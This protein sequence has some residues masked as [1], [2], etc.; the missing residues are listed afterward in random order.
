MSCTAEGPKGQDKAAAPSP[1]APS[2]PPVIEVQLCP[3][4]KQTSL[5][6]QLALVTALLEAALSDLPAVLPTVEGAPISPGLSGSLT[7]GATQ[8]RVRVAVSSDLQDELDIDVGIDCGSLY[9]P[10]YR[11]HASGDPSVATASI[12]KELARNLGKNVDPETLETWRRPQSKDRYARIVLGRGAAVLYRL[13]PDVP[14][15]QRND[16]RADPFERAVFI[17]PRMWVGHWMAARRRFEGREFALARSAFGRAGFYGRGRVLHL[18]EEA[19]ALSAIG[20]TDVALGSW[21]SVLSRAPRDPRYLLSYAEALLDADRLEDAKRT[22]DELGPQA[23][24]DAKVLELRVRIADEGGRE[25]EDEALLSAWA[26]AAPKDP[27][28]VRRWISLCVRQHELSRA[29]GLVPELERRGAVDEARRFGLSLALS[30]GR[31]DVAEADA[32]SL[33]LSEL[34]AAIRLRA[35]LESGAPP[36]SLLPLAKE[37][38]ERVAVAE[39]FLRG[40]EPGRARTIAEEV[41]EVEPH[42]P[43]ALALRA[44]ALEALGLH[45]EAQRARAAWWREDPGLAARV[46]TSSASGGQRW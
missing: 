41:L 28:P 43:E 25:G 14:A 26:K 30:A 3:D 42:L 31:L 16:R 39:A 45:A 22:L 24:A 35:G 15:A 2:L 1:T 36:E 29:M 17:D 18:A 12:A 20:Q 38:L 21:E 34:A 33:G 27:E 9:C 7:V 8:Q 6:P 44:E 5:I 19:R 40:G 11:A 23:G 10:S 13:M 32:R 4:R 37:P 46:E